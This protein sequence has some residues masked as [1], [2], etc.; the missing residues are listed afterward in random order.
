MVA[1]DDD[2]GVEERTMT[3]ASASFGMIV[4]I[5][6][7]VLDVG[8]SASSGNEATSEVRFR[9]RSGNGRSDL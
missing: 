4:E 2:G 3:V 5:G 1:F 7:S 6:L 9:E 8:N